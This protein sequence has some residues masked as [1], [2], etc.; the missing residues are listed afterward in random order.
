MLLSSAAPVLSQVV[1]ALTR[2]CLTVDN[3]TAL[4]RVLKDDDE[5]GFRMVAQACNPVGWPARLEKDR[6]SYR[7]SLDK[8]SS[9]AINLDIAF[10]WTNTVYGTFA[11]CLTACDGSTC[12]AIAPSLGLGLA[13]VYCYQRTIPG[14]YEG[15]QVCMGVWWWCGGRGCHS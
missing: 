13:S 11:A 8:Y 12:N 9:P 4:A 5:S 6:Q 1:N 10:P 15:N 14:Y 2:L 3:S 7:T